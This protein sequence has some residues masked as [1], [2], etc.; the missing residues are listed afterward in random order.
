[1]GEVILPQNHEAVLQFLITLG[2]PARLT[3]VQ[4]FVMKEL[5]LSAASAQ[6]ILRDLMELG[7][8]EKPSRGLYRP[9]EK[10]LAYVGYSDPAK[11]LAAA[12]EDVAS[13]AARLAEKEEL[14]EEHATLLRAQS[15]LEEILKFLRGE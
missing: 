5:D 14:A 3:E 13:V 4:R 9:T 10:G 11:T 1:M 15:L 2:R 12:L 8:V 6:W 7:L